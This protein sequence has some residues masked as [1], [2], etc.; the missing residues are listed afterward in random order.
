MNTMQYKG[1]IAVLSFSEDDDTFIGEV[2]NTQRDKMIF[3]GN[4]PK[5]LRKHFEETI[6]GYLADCRKHGEEPEAPYSGR[7]TYRTTPQNHAS[8]SKY[9]IASGEGSINAFIEQAVQ[10]YT[11][12]VIEKSL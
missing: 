12:H 10:Y 8:L 5:Q 1:Y 7:I 11:K 9:A 3:A 4:T 2:A 6:D